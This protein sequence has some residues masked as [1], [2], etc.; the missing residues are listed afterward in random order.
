LGAH[1]LFCAHAFRRETGVFCLP[2][3]E[4]VGACAAR[5]LL[6]LG[7]RSVCCFS[8]SDAGTWARARYEGISRAFDAHG[9]PGA[10]DGRNLAAA[11]CIQ[12]GMERFTRPAQPW[13]AL[14]DGL[15]A[16]EEPPDA[17]TEARRGE[18]VQAVHVRLNHLAWGQ[19]VRRELRPHMEAALAG[20]GYTVWVGLN[21]EIASVCM[22]FLAAHGI[23]VP[24]DVSVLGFDDTL[25]S[26]TL[27]I[28][29]HNMNP[30]GLAQAVVNFLLRPTRVQRAA[31]NSEVRV[32]VEG[33]IVPR[34]ST[35]AAQ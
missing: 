19:L 3:E 26:F 27:G 29:S 35:A 10:V 5:F 16:L 33:F 34:Q 13:G 28:T 7:H 4:T 8:P 18:V 32:D 20:G 11:D 25:D 24:Q 14:I 1:A 30:A 31:K 17:M 12:K 15:T 21:D 9:F 22:S 2:G 6:S 23:R